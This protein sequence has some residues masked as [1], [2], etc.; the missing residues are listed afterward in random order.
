[1]RETRWR[2]HREREKGRRRVKKWDAD[3]KTVKKKAPTK[4]KRL[5]IRS[6]R[7]HQAQANHMDLAAPVLPQAV[8]AQLGV[9]VLQLRAAPDE[10]LLVEGGPSPPFDARFETGDRVP[11]RDVQL[12]RLV[13]AVFD[14]DSHFFLLGVFST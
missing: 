1:M 9:L 11:G 6:R 14:Y 7:E 5:P 13:T 12:V 8:A 4:R 10:P 3:D 2:Y